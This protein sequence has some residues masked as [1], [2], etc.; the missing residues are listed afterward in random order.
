METTGT[1]WSSFRT[2]RSPLSRVNCSMGVTGTWK[3]FCTVLAR[4][5]TARGAVS[6]N[7]VFREL[8]IK[9]L[10]RNA[11]VNKDAPRC[12]PCGVQGGAIC[13]VTNDDGRL[14]RYGFY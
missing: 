13:A 8:S 6:L 14:D 9:S 3:V 5:E 12:N 2:T 7:I 4:S 10:P 1:E 11:S